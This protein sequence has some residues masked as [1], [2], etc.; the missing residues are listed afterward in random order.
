MKRT[1]IILIVSVLSLSAQS[2]KFL[3]IP[4]ENLKSIHL[5]LK[6]QFSGSRIETYDLE[7]DKY[8]EFIAALNKAS[9][10][11]NLKMNITCYRFEI[12]YSDGRKIEL[13]TNGKGLG[14]TPVGYFIANENLVL[15]YF[16]IKKERYCKPQNPNHKKQG[17]SIGF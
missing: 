14:P 6:D 12:V 10:A 2:D 1:L 11:P 4:S 8:I 16:P 9:E 17:G 5:V 15:N 3:K 13:A 7:A